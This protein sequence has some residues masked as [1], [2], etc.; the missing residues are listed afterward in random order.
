V[1]GVEAVDAGLH[2]LVLGALV[3]V[4]VMA[5]VLVVVLVVVVV[6]PSVVVVSEEV[7]V[8]DVVETGQTN[9]DSCRQSSSP[10]QPTIR[11]FHGQRQSV[12]EPSCPHR[13]E[14][15]SSRSTTPVPSTSSQSKLSQTG[16][17][18]SSTYTE[19]GCEAMHLVCSS[20]APK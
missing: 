1:E 17:S 2:R 6:E 3:D 13:P 10:S 20:S 16:A 7:A 15:N 18:R 5:R 14:A 9:R 8:F 19:K 12:R 4:L 11:F